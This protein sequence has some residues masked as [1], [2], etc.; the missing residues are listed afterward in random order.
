MG[1]KVVFTRFGTWATD[2]GHAKIENSIMSDTYSDISGIRASEI[3][4]WPRLTS[5]TIRIRME[6]VGLT[7]F[8]P[9]SSLWC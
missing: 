7:I 2:P 4:V 9:Y 6:L 3:G 5:R 1:E 8:L